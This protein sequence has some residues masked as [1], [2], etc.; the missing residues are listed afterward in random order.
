MPCGWRGLAEPTDGCVI[1]GAQ[2]AFRWE[3]PVDDLNDPRISAYKPQRRLLL[4]APPGP[5]PR[6]S[7]ARR[8][9]K[10]RA[11]ARAARLHLVGLTDVGIVV[12]GLLIVA[13]VVM[14]LVALIR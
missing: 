10:A 5:R 14:F 4:P 12:M 2:Q 11:D 9:Q 7:K 3:V 1:M 8:E 13:V 6:R